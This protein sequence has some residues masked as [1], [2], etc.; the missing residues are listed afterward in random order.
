MAINYKVS[1]CKN[2]AGDENTDY[3]SC[4][5]SKTSDYSFD[6]LAQ[7]IDPFL[8]PITKRLSRFADNVSRTVYRRQKLHIVYVLYRKRQ[9][10][11]NDV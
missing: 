3:Y 2:P 6:D 11:F 5:A 4:K 1:K 10:L 8:I 7:D 9:T